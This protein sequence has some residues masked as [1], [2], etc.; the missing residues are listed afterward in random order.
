MVTAPKWLERD[1][2]TLQG[3]VVAAARPGRHRLCPSRST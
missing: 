1:K 2:N 3:K